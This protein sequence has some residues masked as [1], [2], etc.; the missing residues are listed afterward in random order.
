MASHQHHLFC[1]IMTLSL[2]GGIC[3]CSWLELTDNGADKKPSCKLS[4][5]VETIVDAASA[6]VS[7]DRYAIR[8]ALAFWGISQRRTRKYVADVCFD[9]I[10]FSFMV[11]IQAFCFW[12]YVFANMST[13][14][15]LNNTCCIIQTRPWYFI[16][17]KALRL[18][19]ILCDARF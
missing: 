19:W 18:S 13:R 10:S 17:L 6:P 12:N 8:R 9:V 1:V 7:C 4:T 5:F 16:F 15:T 2:I 11:S 3:I 14:I